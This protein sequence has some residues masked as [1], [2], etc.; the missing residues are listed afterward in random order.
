MR[1]M[2]MSAYEI[3]QL[4][5]A[6]YTRIMEDT[7]GNLCA[8]YADLNLTLDEANEWLNNIQNNGLRI[9]SYLDGSGICQPCLVD[10]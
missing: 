5:W 3:L 2:K 6:G 7:G 10:A 1:D 9:S 8:P 4:M